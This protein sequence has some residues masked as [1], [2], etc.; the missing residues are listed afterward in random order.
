MPGLYSFVPPNGA[1]LFSPQGT[2]LTKAPDKDSFMVE[3]AV[4]FTICTLQ[5]HAAPC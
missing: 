3:G 5:F 4:S 2:G 1:T